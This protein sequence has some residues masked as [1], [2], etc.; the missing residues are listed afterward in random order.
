M[1]WS[2][3]FT[4]DGKNLFRT[5][6]YIRATEIDAF[7]FEIFKPFVTSIWAL[8]ASL[9]LIFFALLNFASKWENNDFKALSLFLLSF[10]AFCQQSASNRKI[11]LIS[12]Q[13][14]IFFIFF[15]GTLLYNFYTSILVSHL[16]NI[17]HEL[18]VNSL[19]DLIESDA[20]VGFMNSNVVRNYLNVNIK[21]FLRKFVFTKKFHFRERQ[22]SKTCG[23]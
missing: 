16:V 5:F 22:A 11:S 7:S 18:S 13:Y 2:L 10:G 17:K 9:I 20:R 1:F 3:I 14:L 23:S 4:L 8:I 19:D 6:I 21:K 12:T 15:T